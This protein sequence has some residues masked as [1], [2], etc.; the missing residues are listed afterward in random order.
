MFSK[1]LLQNFVVG[2]HFYPN[3]YQLENMLLYTQNS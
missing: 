3:E 2:A 1:D